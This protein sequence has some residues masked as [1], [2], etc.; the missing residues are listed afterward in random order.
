MPSLMALAG[1]SAP[2][3]PERLFRAVERFGHTAAIG[4]RYD[5]HG[6][7][8]TALRLPW[9]P[10]LIGD[11]AAGTLANGVVIAL[12]DMAGGLAIWTTLGHFR[13]VVTL[14]LR[15]DYLR[16]SAQGA[17]MTGRVQCHR[18]ASEIAFVRGVAHDGDV[19]DPVA[20]MTAT[21]MF[22]GPAMPIGTL[23]STA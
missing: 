23:G 15:I 19:G 5:G 22:I 7:D 21:F 16:K 20:T 2:F 8:W 18:V 17:A 11:V 6:P 3:D 1:E 4:L 9:R 12:L 10:D 13:P 14:D